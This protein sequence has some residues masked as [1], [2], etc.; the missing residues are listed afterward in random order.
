MKEDARDQSKRPMFA[1]HPVSPLVDGRVFRYHVG[2][3]S[4]SPKSTFGERKCIQLAAVDPAT[5]PE[6]IS[7]A[8]EASFSSCTHI[9]C[10][11]TRFSDQPERNAIEK[12]YLRF[13]EAKK[14]NNA[15]VRPFLCTINT[16]INGKQTGSYFNSQ[17]AHFRW[18][19]RARL[20]N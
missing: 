13:S 12:P 14:T 6:G 4:P 1:S 11:F 17:K 8:T 16:P 15:G 7:E 18:P 5:A 3:C 19:S 20:P 2:S 9:R 10:L